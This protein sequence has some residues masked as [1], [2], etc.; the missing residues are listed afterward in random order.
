MKTTVREI[1][2]SPEE[3]SEQEVYISGWIRTI[4]S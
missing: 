3:F 2:A 1:Y 4:L